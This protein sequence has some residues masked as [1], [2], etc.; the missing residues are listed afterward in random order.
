MLIEMVMASV[1]WL[2]MFPPIDGVSDKLSPW[3]IVTGMTFDYNMHCQVEFGACAQTH[4]EHDNSMASRTVGAIA[5]RPTENAQGSHYFLSLATGRH[6]FRQRWMEL[7]MPQDVI[8]RVH[9]LAQRSKADT[10]LTFGWR[11]GVEIEDDY[12]SDQD[13]DFDPDETADD[14]TADE[15]DYD[16]DNADDESLAGV[17]PQN[18]NQNQNQNEDEDENN[19]ENNNEEDQQN[20]ADHQPEDEAQEDSTPVSDDKEHDQNNEEEHERHDNHEEDENNNDDQ[21][22]ERE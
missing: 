19:N 17:N 2:N 13:S 14:D 8:D 20:D 21:S 18:Q 5:L 1:F 16:D 9:T 4:E 11:D 12:D 10:G 3:A 7:P 22:T 15:D 6:I